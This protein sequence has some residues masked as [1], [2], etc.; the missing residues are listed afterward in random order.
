MKLYMI[1]HGE[2]EANRLRRHAGWGQVPLSEKGML[3]AEAAGQKLK[4]IPF[5]RV[6][7]SDL[8]RAMQTCEI[9]LPG[10][11]YEKNP[12]LREISVGELS[13]RNAQECQALYGDAY[14][15]NKQRQDF[16]PYG[17]E[18]REMLI[19]RA[20]DFLRQAEQFQE[21]YVAAFTHE[22]VLRTVLEQILQA[23][24]LRQRLLC[25]NCCIAV[26]EYTEGIWRLDGWNI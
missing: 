11:T 21:E 2:S 8:K 4:G 10:C 13:G 6:I 23:P 9:A 18:N 12:L 25:G 3:Q 14:I 19:R 17:G 20:A 5:G 22:G 24:R 1:R 26:F 7:A 15:E 16:T